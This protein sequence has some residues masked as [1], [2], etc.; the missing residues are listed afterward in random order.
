MSE[1]ADI[2]IK[3][4]SLFEFRNYLRREIVELFFNKQDLVVTPAFLSDPEDEDSMG[5]ER[6]NKK[7]RRFI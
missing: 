2:R 3:N 4:L 5:S 6:K 1:F 7:T